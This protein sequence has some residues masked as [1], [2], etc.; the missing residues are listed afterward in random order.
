MRAKS[1][2][3]GLVLFAI[4]ASLPAFGDTLIRRATHRDAFSMMGQNQP[5]QDDTSTLWMSQDRVAMFGGQTDAIVR[6]DQSKVY[7]IDRSAKTYTVLSLPIDLAK[8]V[9]PNDPNAATFT[10]MMEMMKS[11]VSVTP[12]E[13]RKKIGSWNARL[14]HVVFTNKMVTFRSETWATQE[15]KIDYPVYRAMDEALMSLNPATQDAGAE[16]RKIEGIPVLEEQTITVMGS[17]MKM[18]EQTLE[19]TQGKAPSG[20]YDPPAGFTAKPF[21]PMEAMQR[22]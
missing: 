10:Q 22:R 11:T 12:T 1:W 17:E 19:I 5:A 6:L 16:F 9:D 21:N 2:I 7:L 20:V 3:V 8:L 14:Y 15:V 13:E 18:R 4:V